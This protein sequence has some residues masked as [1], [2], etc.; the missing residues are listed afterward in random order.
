MVKDQNNRPELPLPTMPRRVLGLYDQIFWKH[1]DQH[2]LSLQCCSSCQ[3]FLYPPGPVCPNCLSDQ[4]HWTRISGKAS[5]V[6]WVIF[7]RTYLSSY[8]APYNVITA[9]LQEGPLFISNLEGQ[10]PKGSWIGAKVNLIYSE[11]AEKQYLPRFVLD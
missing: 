10:V 5:I 11:M 6:S 2:Q 9:K 8:P 3:T 1:V 7:N 4:L